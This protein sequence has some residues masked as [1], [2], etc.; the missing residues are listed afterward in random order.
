MIAR[1]ALI[2][3]QEPDAK[4][5]PKPMLIYYLSGAEL[6]NPVFDWPTGEPPTNQ[7]QCKNIIINSSV[8]VQNGRHFADEFFICIFVNEKVCILIEISLKFVPKGPVNNKPALVWI[9]AWCRIGDKPLSEP[10]LTRFTDA[11]MR[12]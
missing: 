12:H 10:M 5:F 9:M 3:G 1:L 8:P 2:V 7:M 6:S 4:P 11:Y